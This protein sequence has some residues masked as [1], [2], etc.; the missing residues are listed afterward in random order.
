MSD[1]RFLQDGADKQLSHVI[2]EMGE[3]LA[4]AGKTQRWGWS[5]TNPLLRPGDDFFGESNA[6]WL[7]RELDD[8]EAA[9]ARLRASM[10]RPSKRGL[11]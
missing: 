10:L 11:R 2:E 7:F 8:L 9:I 1:P 4:A 5:S 3:A 6:D